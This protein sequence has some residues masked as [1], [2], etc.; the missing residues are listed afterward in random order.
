MQ[1]L[2]CSLMLCSVVGVARGVQEIVIFWLCFPTCHLTF[3]LNKEDLWDKWCRTVISS[4]WS[5]CKRNHYHYVAKRK[6]KGGGG[7]E[8]GEGINK[9]KPQRVA[10]V[11]F[12]NLV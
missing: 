1:N 11:N 5:I 8:K 12:R 10:F 2:A 4:S 3:T 6:K 9:T 7:E